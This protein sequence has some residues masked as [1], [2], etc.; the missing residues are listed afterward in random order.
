MISLLFFVGII[1]FISRDF[2]YKNPE[3]W[4]L[5]YY[6]EES[7]NTY[8]SG[9]LILTIYYAFRYILFLKDIKVIDNKPNKGKI[10]IN[11]KVKA[12]KIL[13]EPEKILYAKSDG[14]YV[15]VFYCDEYT[16]KNSIIRI[17]IKDFE[18]QLSAYKYII[19][20]HRSHIVNVNH[21]SHIRKVDNGLN[22]EVK[23]IHETI[24]VSRSFIKGFK[25]GISIF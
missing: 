12:D 1:L 15:K 3:N 19:R 22:I 2:F 9:F 20:V 5:K 14:N 8:L 4:S 18:Q 21:I 11:T 16:I 13:I 17:T 23:Q 6:F 7:C 25:R 10:L 24:P